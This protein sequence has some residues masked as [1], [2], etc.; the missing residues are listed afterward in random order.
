MNGAS[1]RRLLWVTAA[2]VVIAIVAVGGYELGASRGSGGATVGPFFGHGYMMG[3]GY[4]LLGVLGSVL[5]VVLVVGL[6]AWIVAPPRG[7]GAGS[8]YYGGPYPRPG[9][10][11]PPSGVEQ[12]QTLA[13]LHDRGQLSDEEFAAA[14]RRLLGL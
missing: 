2:I 10:D 12:L 7:F 1:G 4:G 9:A 6:I 8:G 5:F 3:S 11:Q 13:D 14:K